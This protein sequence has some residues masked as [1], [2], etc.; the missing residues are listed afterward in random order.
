[1]GPSPGH[2]ADLN[3]GKT[4]T[5]I[6]IAKCYGR[7]PFPSPTQTLSAAQDLRPY[8]TDLGYVLNHWHHELVV[9]FRWTTATAPGSR[10]VDSPFT[11]YNEPRH[12]TFNNV[13]F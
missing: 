2:R 9:L 11:Y 4:A 7:M 8:P 3:L 12:V 5:C 1:M 10:P 13:T 6:F